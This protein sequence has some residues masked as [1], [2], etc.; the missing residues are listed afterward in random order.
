MKPTSQ[1]D[2]KS[3]VGTAADAQVIMNGIMRKMLGDGSYYGR[4]MFLYADAKG[5]DLCVGGR[6]RGYDN[7]FVFEHTTVSGTYSG[8]WSQIYH[9][10]AQINNLITNIEIISD[11]G[12]GSGALNHL[13]AQALTARA[14]CY[15]DL[16]RLYG[17]PYDMDKNALGVPLILEVL[18][19]SAQPP[20]AT[21]GEV[22]SQ[23]V[24]DLNAA[25]P[26]FTK[27]QKDNGYINYYAGVSMQ[28][29]VYLQ[30]QNYSAAL[31]AAEEVIDSKIYTLY[32]NDGWVDSWSKQFQTESIFELIYLPIE[33]DLTRSSL[34]SMNIK[35]PS[36]YTNWDY[37]IASDAFLALL[38]E[39]PDDIRWGL[40]G[41][42][43]KSEKVNHVGEMVGLRK[44]CC[45]KYMGGLSCPGDGKSTSTAVNI[46]VI[47]LS[48]IYLIAAEAAFLS[49]NKEKAATYL[50][51]IRQRAP[52][53][54]PA[55]AANVTL[56]MIQ[57][58]RSKELLNEGHRFFD[59]MRWNKSITY[60]DFWTMSPV[61]SRPETIDRTYYKTVL[62][63]DVNEINANPTLKD[64]QNPGY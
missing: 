18:D 33:G 35:T 58:E 54:D 63:I 8:F 45:Y 2:A 44:G 12:N 32:A 62:P 53:L 20:R 57:N 7:L 60:N 55:T 26:L 5:G 21:V 52:N 30:M 38:G 11:A 1:A 56:E 40:M 59:M 49:N 6:G 29:R 42:D 31:T 48:E 28:A 43:E 36:S 51:A 14:I 25:I 34:G 39:D 46:K 27:G 24:A 13:K 64:Q 17:K 61:T 10:L 50:Q 16:V 9:C 4:N 37:F 22:Y 19:A 41:I 15:Y 3:A 47:R 23:I